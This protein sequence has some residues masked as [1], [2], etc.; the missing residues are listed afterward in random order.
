MMDEEDLSA[1]S[2]SSSSISCSSRRT[3]SGGT[4]RLSLA[5]GSPAPSISHAGSDGVYELDE[6][7]YL[8]LGQEV[9]V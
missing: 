1:G 5:S 4:S 8:V 6:P 3:A 7:R 2:R 9:D